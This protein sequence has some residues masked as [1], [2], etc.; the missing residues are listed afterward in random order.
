LTISENLPK[1]RVALD[2][3]PLSLSVRDLACVRGERP[4][5]SQIDFDLAAGEMLTLKGPNGAGKSS[6]IRQVAG[7]LD[8][9]GGAIELLGAAEGETVG[10]HALYAGHLDAVK[11]PLSVFEN[12]AFWADFYGVA[13]AMIDP[14]LACFALAHLV[15]LPAS[16]LSAGQKRRLGLARLALIPRPIWLLDEPTVSLDVT[17]VARLADL[18]RTHLKQ[19]GLILA[20]THIDL[21]IGSRELHL[22]EAPS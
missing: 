8:V 22:G 9:S 21:G 14:A 20:A 15:S 16:V 10:D 13:R 19:G 5:F 1:G 2:Y 12:M 4:V 3:A 6:L 11:A 18:M 17:S 7:L